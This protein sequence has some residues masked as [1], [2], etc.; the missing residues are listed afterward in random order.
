MVERALKEAE[1]ETE[2]ED[3]LRARQKWVRF[4]QRNLYSMWAYHFLYEE[5]SE[6]GVQEVVV[7]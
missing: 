3:L 2:N 7:F 6:S 4:L 5:M 1:G